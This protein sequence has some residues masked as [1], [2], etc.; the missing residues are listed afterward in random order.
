MS[1]V[2]VYGSA[3]ATS[4]L[5]ILIADDHAVALAGLRELF[6][7]CPRL[8][9]V[10][11]ATTGVEANFLRQRTGKGGLRSASQLNLDLASL[12]IATRIARA[13]SGVLTDLG[14]ATRIGRGPSVV[15][16]DISKPYRSMP[17]ILADVTSVAFEK[18]WQ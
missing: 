8:H 18:A 11:E 14:N 5:R 6:S 17:V 2:P 3:R 16:A 1:W 12:T 13:S 4:T 10:G 9:V 7:E 15:V